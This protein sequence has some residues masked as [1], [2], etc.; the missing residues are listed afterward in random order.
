MIQQLL[1]VNLRLLMV[2]DCT[3]SALNSGLVVLDVAIRF[4]EDVLI[5]VFFVVAEEDCDDVVVL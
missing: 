3:G 1:D 2:V 5:E 4:F